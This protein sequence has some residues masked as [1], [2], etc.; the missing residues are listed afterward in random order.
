MITL[1]KNIN[2]EKKKKRWKKSSKIKLDLNTITFSTNQFD[3]FF[4]FFFKFYQQQ[5]DLKKR[6]RVCLSK[7]IRCLK[8][9]VA[10]MPSNLGKFAVFKGKIEEGNIYILN[11]Y[12]F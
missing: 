5:C 6:H 11:I 10:L 3:S 2:E 12:Q 7:N 4:F 8:N 1:P 9:N